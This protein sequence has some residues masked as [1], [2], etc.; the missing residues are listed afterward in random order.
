MYPELLFHWF[1]KITYGLTTGI[2]MIIGFLL[3]F[4]I[5]KVEVSISHCDTKPS[6]V[7]I[8]QATAVNTSKLDDQDIWP[9]LLPK[10]DTELINIMTQSG[11]YTK[12]DIDIIKFYCTKEC[13]H[14]LFCFDKSPVC[15]DYHN[16]KSKRRNPMETP[17]RPSRCNVIDCSNDK[18]HYAHCQN[19][20][21]YHPLIYGTQL[22]NDV[23]ACMKVCAFG[24][25]PEL[26]QRRKM[27]HQQMYLEYNKMM[28][29]YHGSSK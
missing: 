19:E 25:D 7:I 8:H 17:Y 14:G 21:Q 18:C 27:I 2:V 5:Q 10:N 11:A 29:Q 24:H 20:V 12:R 23:R 28:V 15:D 26:I 1:I 6:K 3:P 9:S 16:E 4:S 13:P 22:C